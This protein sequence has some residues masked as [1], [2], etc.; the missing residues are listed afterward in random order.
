M[1]YP[2]IKDECE[3]VEFVTKVNDSLDAL[4]HTSIIYVAAPGWSSTVLIFQLS[5]MTWDAVDPALDVPTVGLLLSSSF[6][7]IG[8][9][10]EEKGIWMSGRVIDY[11]TN[12]QQILQFDPDVTTGSPWTVLD[13]MPVQPCLRQFPY[14]LNYIVKNQQYTMYSAIECNFAATNIR[15]RTYIL[16]IKQDDL[17]YAVGMPEE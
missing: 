13:N 4:Q 17:E 14:K 12:N 11:S 5:T 6:T 2:S 7:Y 16:I 3:G 10:G 9:N 8:S 15:V 1:Y